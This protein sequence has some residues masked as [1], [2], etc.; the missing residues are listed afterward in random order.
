MKV[1]IVRSGRSEYRVEAESAV[2][3]EDGRTA[4]YLSGELMAVAPKRAI[5]VQHVH[6]KEE[7]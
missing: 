3:L 1:W 4:F 6:Q 5:I 7:V 2:M